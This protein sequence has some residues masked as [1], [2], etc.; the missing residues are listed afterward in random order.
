MR[1]HTAL[2]SSYKKD[3]PLLRLARLLADHKWNLLASAGTSVYLKEKM[4]ECRDVGEIVGSPILGHRVVTLSRELY[5]GLLAST[6]EDFEEL[7][8]LG[9]P[10]IDLVYVTLY[11]LEEAVQKKESPDEIIEKTDIGGPTLL[12]AAA[13]GRRLT[14]SR[15]EQID[16]LVKWLEAGSREE[17]RRE[18]VMQFAA[19]AERRVADY[20]VTSANYWERN[21]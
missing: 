9:I 6:E 17:E 14:L 21:V 13:K 16:I 10:R 19:A 2:L 8:K 3:E 18:I 15:P 11:P 7:E 4:I 5:A 20:V 12:R 1:T